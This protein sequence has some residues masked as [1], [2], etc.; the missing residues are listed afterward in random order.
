MLDLIRSNI[1][2]AGYHVML[3]Q[4]G[5]S[6]RFAYT[7]GLTELDSPELVLAGATALDKAQAGQAVDA[8]VAAARNGL[9]TRGSVLEVEGVGRFVLADVHPTWTRELLLGALRHY[10]RED[11]PALQLVPEESLR[12]IDV[13]DLDAPYD[14]ETAPVWRWLT[15]PWPYAFPSE[16]TV[17]THLDALH[18][19][20]VTE[21][22]RWEEDYWEV[23][24]GDGSE[25][26]HE[27]A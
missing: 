10:D 1:A 3:V 20:A 27:E 6:P 14:P 26:R 15:E 9:A 24:S 11:V 2:S 16:A 19:H 13:P 8:A 4:G 22:A 25:V 17:M 23:F 18:G 5:A 12:T 21:A 7:V